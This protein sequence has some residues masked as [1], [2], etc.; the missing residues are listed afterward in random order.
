MSDATNESSVDGSVAPTTDRAT[1]NIGE[2]R[3]WQSLLWWIPSRLWGDLKSDDN[4]K[5]PIRETGCAMN[6]PTR[7]QNTAE[8]QAMKLARARRPSSAYR[9]LAEGRITL[10]FRLPAEDGT[11]CSVPIDKLTRPA[12]AQTSTKLPPITSL[13]FNRR[14]ASTDDRPKAGKQRTTNCSQ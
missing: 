11:V 3:S 6:T 9:T 14:F 2:V 10:C 8:L 5:A 13:A 4:V 1:D 12:N 7:R